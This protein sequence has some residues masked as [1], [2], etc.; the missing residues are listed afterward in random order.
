MEPQ[1]QTP[2]RNRKKNVTSEII[3]RYNRWI[4]GGVLRFHRRR[5]MAIRNHVNSIAWYLMQ[6]QTPPNLTAMLT[7]WRAMAWKFFEAPANVTELFESHHTAFSRLT[8]IQDDQ[9]G[10]QRCQDIELV[11]RSLYLCQIGRLVA[12]SN[13]KA[14]T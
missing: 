4:A 11:A 6:A 10:G 1:Q 12:R 9:K 14:S 3:T 13:T 5:N 8:L 7:A 2:Q